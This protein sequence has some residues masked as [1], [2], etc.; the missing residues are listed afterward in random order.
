MLLSLLFSSVFF[1]LFF[2]LTFDYVRLVLCLTVQSCVS[3]R[4]LKRL[5]QPLRAFKETESSGGFYFSFILSFSHASRFNGKLEQGSGVVAEWGVVDG[6]EHLGSCSWK[7]QRNKSLLLTIIQTHVQIHCTC[8]CIMQGHN[9]IT[10]CSCQC[11]VSTQTQACPYETRTNTLTHTLSVLT[12]RRSNTSSGK[13]LV[14]ASSSRAAVG[15]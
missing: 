5:K 6:G 11:K 15:F 4:E 7:R 1:C 13:I 2:Y 12:P 3:P 8:L 10:I 9:W 14:Q